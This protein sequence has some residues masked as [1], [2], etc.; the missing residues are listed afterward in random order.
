[1]QMTYLRIPPGNVKL[2]VTIDQGLAEMYIQLQSF[3]DEAASFY[4]VALGKSTEGRFEIL[5]TEE[6]SAVQ[7]ST[8]EKNILITIAN[9]VDHKI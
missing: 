5:P 4:N 1:M 6:G 9:R 3:S 7:I 8:E 2:S